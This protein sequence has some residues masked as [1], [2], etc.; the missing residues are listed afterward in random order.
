VLVDRAIVA[1]EVV[2]Q[3]VRRVGEPCPP[4]EQ[5]EDLALVP[6]HQPRIGSLVER[7]TPELHAVLLAE[8]V[9]LA[10]AEHRQPGHRGH[11]HRHA[12]V[13]VALAELLERRLLVRVAHEVDVPLEDLRVEL[14]GVPDHL[15]V[16][17]AVLV[18]KHVHE[19]AVVDAVHA[20]G[21][22][23]VALEQPERLGQ[24]ERVGTSTATRST[25]SRQNSTGM[26]RSN[27]AWVMAPDSARDGMPPGSPGSGHHNRLMCF[28]AST[29][30]ASNRMIGKRRATARIVWM[31]VPGQPGRGSRA[32]PCHSTGRSCR[33]C[34]GTGM[35][36]S[37]QPAPPA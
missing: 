37:H 19:R 29:I 24:Q 31:T 35:S 4:V 36:R 7:R 25:T 15:P 3:E 14:D 26:R 20:E 30:A 10:M 16:A 9:D 8:A 33:R 5:R 32:A 23:E 1:H 27:S 6:L 22:H 12:E 18:T 17:R 11:D 2:Q 28:L 21:P 13:L 34:R